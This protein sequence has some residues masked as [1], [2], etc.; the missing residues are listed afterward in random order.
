MV[1][2]PSNISRRKRAQTIVY[3]QLVN[4]LSSDEFHEGDPIWQ[5]IVE[6]GKDRHLPFKEAIKIACKEFDI[7]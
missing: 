6:L 5:R 3:N 1:N 4:Y 7:K 2:I